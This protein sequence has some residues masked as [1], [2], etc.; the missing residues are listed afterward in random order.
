M[1]KLMKTLLVLLSLAMVLALFAGC[2]GPEDS[3]PSKTEAG[4]SKPAAESSSGEAPKTLTKVRVGSPSGLEVLGYAHWLCA[5]YMGYFEEEGLEVE[6]VASAGADVCKMMVAGDV[7]LALPA[8]AVI[9][10]A[11][12]SGIDMYAVYQHDCTNIFGFA[13]RADSDIYEWKDLEGKALVTDSGWFLFSDPILET[14]GVDISTM[15]YVSAKE[16]RSVM[17]AAGT[18]D[19]ALTW[20]KEWQLWD[21]QGIPLRYLDGE[22]VLKNSANAIVC[23]PEYY[24]NNKEVLAGLGR[25]LAKGTYFCEVNPLA[26]SAITVHRWPTLDLVAEEAEPSI[27]ALVVCSTPTSGRY[28]E[29]ELSRW[30]T[31]LEWLARYDM[32]D[33]SKI[34]LK[35][36]LKSE[37]LLD[38][39]N[40]WDRET[41]EKQAKEFDISSVK[42]WS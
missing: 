26:A 11:L 29:T 27:K 21:A 40:D 2:K 22:E 24:E 14:A 8:P 12:T 6:M 28:G 30:E 19:A 39:Y 42:N 4:E 7:Q 10:P 25:A 33:K 32:V 37:D 23:Q 16:E 38:A 34:D 13:V 31:G 1:K 36:L 9:Y 20:Q 41:V 5:E 17:L 15:D 3:E 18:V 35:K